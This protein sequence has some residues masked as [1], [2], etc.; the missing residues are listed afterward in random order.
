[1][2]VIKSTVTEK[3]LCCDIL[4]AAHLGCSQD[5]KIVFSDKIVHFSAVLLCLQSSYL[6]NILEP[7]L[8]DEDLVLILPD[9]SFHE[10]SNENLGSSIIEILKL[11]SIY[12]NHTSN[13]EAKE[14]ATTISDTGLSASNI[15][16]YLQPFTE[17]PANL[18][19]VELFDPDYLEDIEIENEENLSLTIHSNEPE[20][21][22]VPQPAERKRSK[23]RKKCSVIL[24]KQKK[25]LTEIY[26]KK[27]PKKLKS[28]EIPDL[29]YICPVCKVKFAS[30]FELILHKKTHLMQDQGNRVCNFCGKHFKKTFQLQN[31]IR[32]H[33]GDKP[34]VCHTCGKAFSQES[35]LKTHMR[36]HTGVK[37]FQCKE[38]DESFNVSSALTAHELWKHNSGKRPFLCTFCSKSFPTKSAVRK[39]ETIH[40]PDKKHSCDYC[41]KKFARADHLKSHLKSHKDDCLIDVQ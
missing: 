30:E 21:C 40:K 15:P 1:M 41:P 20:F 17:V 12:E 7:L 24:K 3:Q 10:S 35:T 23:K 33:T 19:T 34:F 22:V 5:V 27:K 11:P 37:P 38:C 29:N 26:K 31:H 2:T 32:T 8:Q 28:T 14:S 25:G 39:H 9:Q 6:K 13:S 16:E 18:E 36:I 4:E